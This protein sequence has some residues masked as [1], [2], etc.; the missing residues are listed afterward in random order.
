MIGEPFHGCAGIGTRRL[1]RQR[2]SRGGDAIRESY[3]FIWII[4]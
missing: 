3:Q 4:I 1:A 2:E